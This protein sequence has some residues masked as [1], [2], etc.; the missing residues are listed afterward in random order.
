MTV[1][2]TVA[3][4]PAYPPGSFQLAVMSGMGEALSTGRS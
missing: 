3:L 4:N 2:S 1:G